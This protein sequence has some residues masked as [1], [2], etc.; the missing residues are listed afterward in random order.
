MNKRAVM[1]RLFQFLA[2]YKS[3]A[4]AAVVVILLSAALEAVPPRVG[5]LIIDALNHPKS[6]TNPLLPVIQMVGI[7]VFLRIIAGGL[8]YAQR[9]L[10][11]WLGAKLLMDIRVSIYEKFNTLSLGYYDKRSVGSVMSRITSDSDNLWDF[12]TDGVPWF[13]SNVLTFVIIGSILLLMNWQLTLL[14][15]IPGPLLFAL[16]RWFMP[17]GR[18][19]WQFLHQRIN[20]MNSSIKQHFERDAGRESVCA[21]E[22]GKR[23]LPRQE[24]RGFSGQLCRERALGHVLPGH[25]PA[26]GAGVVGYLAIRR[27]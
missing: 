16:T 27:A 22:S 12:L 5:G 24:R 6:A 18:Q 23:P 15:M 17:R 26:D 8:Q 10:N 4:V 9:R 21:G 13:M 1:L 19:R 25:G 11:S 7:L 2:P 3:L 20:R 14:V